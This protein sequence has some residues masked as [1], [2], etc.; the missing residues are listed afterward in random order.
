MNAGLFGEKKKHNDGNDENEGGGE[1]LETDPGFGRLVQ[2]GGRG[3][4]IDD[5]HRVLI[6]NI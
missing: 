4:K 1:D 2:T 3:R 6:N 5:L